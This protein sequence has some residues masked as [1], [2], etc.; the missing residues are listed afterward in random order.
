MEHAVFELGLALAL[1]GVAGLLAARLKISSVPFMIVMGMLLGPH[2]PKI[3]LIDLT[4]ARELTIFAFMGRLGVLFLLF[5][6]GLE[7]SIGRLVRSGKNILVAGT[8]HVG[9]SL[10]CGFG[11]GLL[12]AWPL[13]EVLVAAGA[14]TVTSSAII[15]KV[16][17]D[18]KRTANPE[19]ELI[20]GIVMA[21]DLFLA[22]YLSI[23]SGFVLSG[24]TSPGGVVASAA[25]ALGF[26]AG[27][28]V[29]SRLAM[30]WINGF[31]DRL[32]DEL[33]LLV[34][35]AAL[36]LVAGFGESLHVAEAIGALLFGLAL[37]E[38][39]HRERLEHLIL[40]F[41]DFFGALF[42]F[43]FG[44]SIDPLG[45]GGAVIPALIAALVSMLGNFTAG[46]LA[47]RSAGLSH[48]AS[49]N[50]GLT[51]VARGEFSI[52]MANLGVAGGLLPVLQPFAA[53]YV[54]ILAVLGPVLAKH[55][56]TIYDLLSRVFRWKRIPPRKRKITIPAA[57][58]DG[59]R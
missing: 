47:G 57:A 1:I 25:T 31:L 13:K 37:A 4:F 52:V 44:L 40:P 58:P 8:I 39:D 55:S 22:V 2:A 46:M 9:I 54:L 24:A 29:L 33:F 45:L 34:V 49:A 43:S 23:V 35:F 10:L 20:L 28:L 3:G 19:T 6:L 7:F 50:I 51:I 12:M 48:R 15:A 18:L 17:V 30:P 14:M 42:F 53:L 11:F 21:D 38:S 36:F 27:V 56:P 16:L 41:R 59:R 32:S 26:M 5:Y